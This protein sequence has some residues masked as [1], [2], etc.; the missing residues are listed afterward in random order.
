M[1]YP[2][3][4]IKWVGGKHKLLP[5][6]LSQFPVNINNYHELFLGGGSVLLGLLTE[7]NNNNIK[8]KGKIRAYD[9]NPILI[10]FYKHLQKDWK[11]VYNTVKKII[12]A[13][14]KCDKKE[15]YYYIRN[16]YNGRKD[17]DISRVA[18]FVYL[19]KTGFRGLF[20]LNQS[21]GYN[22]PYGNYK[23]PQIVNDKHLKE[24]NKL[25]K[26]VEFIC[27]DFQKVGR[28]FNADDFVYM[29]P[30]YVPEVKN[31]FVN[32]SPNGFNE[33]IHKI[34][35]NFTNQLKCKFVMSN[36][37]T[38]LVKTELKNHVMI[39]I[40]ARRAINSKNPQSKV[41]ELIIHNLI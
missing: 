33:N 3:S 39:E 1:T 21:G 26:N 6:I 16:L 14:E 24:I 34:L 22:V 4:P 31:G 13:G 10:E 20:R 27:C 32:Y 29:D 19:N 36:S 2:K 12:R 25:I 18:E 37:N 41:K 40:E 5:K 35:F 23:N 28:D 8:V 38:E 17:I 15:Y 7:I 11:N 9:S 30:P